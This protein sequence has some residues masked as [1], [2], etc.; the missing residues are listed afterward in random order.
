MVKVPIFYKNSFFSQNSIFIKSKKV[1]P[2]KVEKSYFTVGNSGLVEK[3]STNH[4]NY[5]K[6]LL[7]HFV[8]ATMR[9]NTSLLIFVGV[10]TAYFTSYVSVY[11]IYA[12]IHKIEHP[13][14]FW[15]IMRSDKKICGKILEYTT[16]VSSVYASPLL[17]VMLFL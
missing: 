8:E 13:S 9:L 7:H 14:P 2:V 4:N 10:F 15:T 1:F 11:S 3:R 16:Y 17:L 5:I 6:E 12:Y